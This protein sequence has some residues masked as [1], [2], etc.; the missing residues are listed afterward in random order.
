MP[1]HD[2]RT[3]LAILPY[4]DGVRLALDAF[5]IAQEAAR[6][7]PATIRWYRDRLGRFLQFLF[8][9]GVTTLEAITA[10]DCRLFLASLQQKN[11]KDNTIHGYARALR[12]FFRFL[13]GDGFLTANPWAT[14][15]MPKKDKRI[16]PALT[17]D[18]V[19]KLLQ[20]CQST[21]DRALILCLLDSA[22]RAS[23]FVGLTL[24][25]VELSTGRVRIR[26]GKGAKDRICF[27]GAKARRELVRYVRERGNVGADSPL[28]VSQTTGEALTYWGLQLL[29]RRLGRKAGIADC[30]PHTFRR[31]AAIWSLRAGMSIYHLQALM[32]HSD[33]AVLRQYLDLVESDA[34][35]AHRRFGAVD[36]ML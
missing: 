19:R 17:P 14:V 15:K 3:P 9:R 36:N 7:S 20:V 4:P 32:G 34:Q 33:L 24:G 26:H 31:T 8:D 29:L 21:R 25:D 2:Q 6:H 16:L 35:E 5:L 28:W 10:T 18:D 13:V 1:K 27:L 12:C 22:A 30:S 23:E 11:L